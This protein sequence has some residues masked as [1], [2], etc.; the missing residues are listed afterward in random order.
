MEGGDGFSLREIDHFVTNMCARKPIVFI[1]KKT[2]KL[3]DINS[4]Y[5]N[6]LR[7]YHKAAF[8]T[9]NRK[10]GSIMKQRKFFKWAIE[11]GIVDYAREHINDIKVDMNSTDRSKN[12][13]PTIF[14]VNEPQVKHI[15]ISK[16]NNIIW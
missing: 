15:T 10:G 9:F 13:R 14:I 4:D 5:R 3:V 11:T 7:C 6:E 1:N 16:F 12:K 8:D 2:G